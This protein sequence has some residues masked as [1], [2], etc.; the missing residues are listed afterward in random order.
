MTYAGWEARAHA[1]LPPSVLSYVAGG[2]GGER[3]QEANVRA[4]DRWGL[5]PRMFVGAR[6][7]TCP[8]S[9]SA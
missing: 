7:A 1:A 5:I 9:C 2:A 6:G 3:T 8:W 4:F